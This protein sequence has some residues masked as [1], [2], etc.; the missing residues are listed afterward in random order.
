MENAGPFDDFRD[1][2]TALLG[3][4]TK[5]SN[6]VEN[7]LMRKNDSAFQP[8]FGTYKHRV[9][10]DAILSYLKHARNADHHSI[11]ESVVAD[12]KTSLE[13]KTLSGEPLGPG[14]SSR[15]VVGPGFVEISHKGPPIEA[16]VTL[17]ET[18]L[19]PVTDSHKKEHQPPP[20]EL[21]KNRKSVV[22][23]AK[24]GLDFYR[25]LVMEAGKKFYPR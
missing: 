17:P 10:T 24:S 25:E 21:G 12:P 23:I 14:C 8:W 9:R 1:A 16:K 7:E 6:K 5:V 19:L 2:W 4:L 18:T 22:K 20:L 3:S 13:I 11:E 15:F